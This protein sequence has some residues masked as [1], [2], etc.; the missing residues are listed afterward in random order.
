V[1]TLASVV[2]DASKNTDNGA[3]PLT[4]LGTLERVMAPVE[5]VATQPTVTLMVL[6][7][8]VAVGVAHRNE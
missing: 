2:A 5:L 8:E 6:L 1:V 7:D 4:R 3:T